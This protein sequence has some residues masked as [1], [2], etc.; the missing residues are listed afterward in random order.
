MGK[1]KEITIYYIA[2]SLKISIATVSHA[3][4]NDPVVKKIH[5]ENIL[6]C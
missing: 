4:K 3:L 6:I 2:T 1:S 5:A